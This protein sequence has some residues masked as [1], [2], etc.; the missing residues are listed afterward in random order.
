VRDDLPIWLSTL[1][2]RVLD[3]RDLQR[4]FEDH[5][6][7]LRRREE[8]LLEYLDGVAQQGDVALAYD[9]P[10]I[11]S[12]GALYL[13]HCRRISVSRSPTA[14]VQRA[15]DISTAENLWGLTYGKWRKALE[16]KVNPIP[17]RTHFYRLK[18]EQTP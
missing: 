16:G 9:R 2:L 10:E 18:G 3:Q 15:I 14:H 5:A 11:E 1:Y 6:P 8:E 4:E 13:D 12:R 7:E 17:S